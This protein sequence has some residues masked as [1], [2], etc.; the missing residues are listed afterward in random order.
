VLEVIQFGVM[1]NTYSPDFLKVN[2]L[3]A[4]TITKA[5]S[6]QA[7]YTIRYL[8]DR[9]RMDD[10]YRAYAY[11]RWV[12][13]C[14]DQTITGKNERMA[15]LKRQTM[16]IEHCYR[17]KRLPRVC[18]E[19]SMLVDLI[20]CDT[21]AKSGL[22]SYIRNMMAVMTFDA[23]RKG[24]LISEQELNSY[25]QYLAIAVTE[26]LY[27]FIGN[28]QSAPQTSGRYLAAT[29]AHIVHMLRDTCED[30]ANGYFNIPSEILK[31]NR[32][33]PGNVNSVPYKAW[34]KS[35]IELARRYFQAGNA[36]FAQV[37]SLRCRIACYA[38]M[39]RFQGVLNTIV[40]D[41]YQLRASYDECNNALTSLKMGWFVCSQSIQ[42]Q[43]AAS[44]FFTL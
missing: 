23:E 1:D 10:A 18:A 25:S 29:A 11:F 15:F 20:H 5:A 9:D 44:V 43:R 36:Y 27:F 19:E 37:S 3:L 12:D 7:F 26:A 31:L 38:Y 21:E 24:R 42:A 16:L 8:V 4:P 6:K 34:V 14:L 32:I 2:T 41:G 33:D 30:I 22:Q 28:G 13:D 39:A 40:R 17:G 35:R